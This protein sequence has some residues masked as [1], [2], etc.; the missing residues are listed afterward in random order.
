M[1][2]TYTLWKVSK[3]GLISGPYFPVFSPIQEIVD[4]KYS[5]FEHFLRSEANAICFRV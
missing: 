4:Q 2:A 5:V 3:Y 1:I